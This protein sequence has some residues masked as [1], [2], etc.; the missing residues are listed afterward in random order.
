MPVNP[1]LSGLFKATLEEDFIITVRETKRPYCKAKVTPFN[2]QLKEYPYTYVPQDFWVYPLKEGDIIV[3]YFFGE[4]LQY[5]VLWNVDR[6]FPASVLDAFVP[7]TNGSL[8]TAPALDDNFSFTIYSSEIYTL[9]QDELI[10]THNKDSVVFQS[11][12]QVK[13]FTKT[14][15]VKSTDIQLEGKVEYKS[16]GYKVG[17]TGAFEITSN[18]QELVALMKEI[19]AAVNVA[20]LCVPNTGVTTPSVLVALSAVDVKLT[21][22][23][24]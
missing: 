2:D 14:Y 17:N 9:Y 16:S 19:V 21:T 10:I 4:D 6:D 18:S 24:G 23:K 22:F 13:I 3:V 12:D 15:G 11:K 1:I 20:S 5:P 8:V 7:P